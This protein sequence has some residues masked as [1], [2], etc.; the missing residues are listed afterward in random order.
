MNRHS[1]WMIIV[2]VGLTASCVDKQE[3]AREL[4]SQREVVRE[5]A[6]EYQQEAARKL[7]GKYQ[8]NS[9][10]FP[11]LVELSDRT[12]SESELQSAINIMMIDKAPAYY[13][14]L[15]EEELYERLESDSSN[16]SQILAAKYWFASLTKREISL[17]SLKKLVPVVNRLT[18]QIPT[19]DIDEFWVKVKDTAEKEYASRSLEHNLQEIKRTSDYLWNDY[20]WSNGITTRRDVCLPLVSGSLDEIVSS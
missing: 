5:L 4:A 15:S 19:L 3:T 20:V 7:V 11:E 1:I 12:N 6:R 8:L 17:D 2:A 16:Y 13:S 18:R 14:G 9:L 10:S